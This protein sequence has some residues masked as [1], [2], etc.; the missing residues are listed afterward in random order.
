MGAQL[1]S[2]PFHGKMENRSQLSAMCVQNQWFGA[3]V[4]PPD[5][6]LIATLGELK[7]LRKCD[8]GPREVRLEV[9]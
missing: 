5:G 9:F 2:A 4:L 7:N 3:P 1:F 6:N 8:Y